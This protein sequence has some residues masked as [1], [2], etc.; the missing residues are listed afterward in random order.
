MQKQ[1]GVEDVQL[2]LTAGDRREPADSKHTHPSS[3]PKGANQ[4][5]FQLT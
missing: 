3:S 1:K 4:I 5:F 2:Y